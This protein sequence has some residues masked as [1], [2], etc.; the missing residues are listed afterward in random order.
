MTRPLRV[1]ARQVRRASRS[2]SVC[3][4][5]AG[6]RSCRAAGEVALKIAEFGSTLIDRCRS[7]WYCVEAARTLRV[8]Y[9]GSPICITTHHE[10][11]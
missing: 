9:I 11:H 3:E 8:V 4:P 1:E 6:P 10:R 2:H 5:S 7:F